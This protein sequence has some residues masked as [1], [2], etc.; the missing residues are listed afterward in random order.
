MFEVVETSARRYP[1]KPAII[2]YG[3]I[4]T[5]KELWESILSFAGYLNTIGIKKGDRV[6][7]FLPNSPQ[8]VIAYYGIMR[9]NAIVV[10]LDPMLSS[11]GMKELLNDS[12]S[13]AIVTMAMSLPI[14]N[15]IKNDTTLEKIIASEFEDYIPSEP[16]LPVPASMLQKAGVDEEALS[17]KE[18]IGKKTDPPPIEVRCEDPSLIMYTSGTTGD[19]KGALHTHWS[20]M[21]NSLR[22]NYWLFNV[23]ST[24]HL[25]VLPFF[26]VTGMHFCMTAPLY[27]GATLVILSRWDRE[28]ALQAVEK[29]HCTHWT[30][31]TTMVVDMLS[32][33]DIDSRNLSSFLVFGGGGSP[34]PKAIGGK[35]SLNGYILYGGI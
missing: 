3:K 32:A 29:Y 14:I 31:I 25:A 10:A 33:P 20:M 11:E 23:P 27:S 17:W 26:H 5:Y 21:V 19:R 34:V 1:E 4:V 30:N 7:V 28:T 15:K 22:A 2:Y 13:K 16:E 9:A 6:A 12:Q 8:F 35:I 18:V 24:V